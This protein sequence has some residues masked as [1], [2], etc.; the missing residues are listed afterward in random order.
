MLSYIFTL[1][2][3]NEA[4]SMTTLNVFS[5]KLISLPEKHTCSVNDTEIFVPQNIV[6][7]LKMGTEQQ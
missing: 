5:H 6:R 7:M 2:K 1:S 3:L 4:Y